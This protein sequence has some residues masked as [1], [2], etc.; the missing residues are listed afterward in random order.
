MARQGCRRRKKSVCHGD[1][2]ALVAFRRRIR[3]GFER[4]VRRS[5]NQGAATADVALCASL[6]LPFDVCSICTGSY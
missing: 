5:E 6:R 3:F 4:V 1:L 2:W